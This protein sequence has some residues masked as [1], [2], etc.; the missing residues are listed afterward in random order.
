MSGKEKS[1]E[2]QPEL[3]LNIHYGAA[4][5]KILQT[6]VELGIFTHIN[7]GQTSVEKISRVLGSNHR[8]IRIFLDALVGMGVL[9]KARGAYKLTAESKQF[10]VRGES[11]YLGQFL[12]GTG[13]AQDGWQHLTHAVKKGRQISEFAEVGHRTTFFKELVKGI[14]PTS[15]ASGVILGKKL[16]VGKTL[17]AQK[18]LDLGCGA[19]PWSIAMAMADQASKVVAVD[20][21]EILEIAQAH[22]KRFHVNRQ[23]EWRP[24]DFHEVKFEKGTYDL[25]I[26]GHILH[27]EG[28][29]PSKK[30][31]KRAHECLKPG[32][33]LLIAEFI[34]NDLKSGPELP[35]LFAI[36][37]LLYTD[38]GDVFTTKDLKRWLGLCGFKKTSALAVQ[39]PVTVMVGTK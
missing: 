35:F 31:I 23:F 21:P 11:Q 8:A 22:V 18:I 25:V 32:G 24:G 36:N 15:F 1:V 17:K 39:Y 33:K 3:I 12:T 27:G 28:E 9:A 6:A 37:M 7:E 26:L 4:R 30:L 5:S 20:F 13:I 16:G 38:G 2:I 19:A 34:A 10:L 29:L 14:F